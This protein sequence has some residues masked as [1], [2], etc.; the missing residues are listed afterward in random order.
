[1]DFTFDSKIDKDDLKH[2]NIVVKTN[3]SNPNSA[4]VGFVSK[5][6]RQKQI[7]NATDPG[8]SVWSARKR[9]TVTL[10]IKIV[11]AVEAPCTFLGCLKKRSEKNKKYSEN[12]KKYKENAKKY[13]EYMR[14]YK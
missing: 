11:L 3:A 13:K 1:M 14:K 8:K 7:K 2:Q 4:A 10:I 12:T 9:T 6:E 5:A